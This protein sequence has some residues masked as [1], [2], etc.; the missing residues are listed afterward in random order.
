MQ[1]IRI[2]MRDGTTRD[3]PHQG[4]AG[5]SYTKTI[6]YEGSMAIITD[7]WGKQIVIPVELIAEVQVNPARGYW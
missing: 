3:F 4:R 2:V 6:K 7:E 5:G 1:D